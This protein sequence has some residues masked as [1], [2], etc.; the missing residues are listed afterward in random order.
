VPVERGAPRQKKRKV[1][2][3]V[4]ISTRG[5]LSSGNGKLMKASA[6]KPNGQKDSVS[7]V[8]TTKD[9]ELVDLKSVNMEQYPYPLPDRVPRFMHKVMEMMSTL[10]AIEDDVLLELT[11]VWLMFEKRLGYGFGAD[12]LTTDERP[13][14]VS[15]WIANA[16]RSNFP[17]T[18]TDIDDYAKKMEHWW[19]NCN[20]EWRRLRDWKLTK[21]GDGPWEELRV[22]GVNGIVNV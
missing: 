13:E 21:H 22:S 2:P 20:P 12:R 8:K 15:T 5:S 4:E 14:Q 19:W 6:A 7:K 18:I 17:G 1:Q 3:V 11:E 16:R 9:T 10:P